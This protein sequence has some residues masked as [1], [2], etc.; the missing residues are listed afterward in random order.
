MGASY[1]SDGL[2]D[3][4]LHMLAQ[5]KELRVAARTSAF[6]GRNPSVEVASIGEQLNVR[7]VLEGS[8]QLSGSEIR[9]TAQLIDVNSGYHLWSGGFDRELKDIFVIQ[10]EIAAEVVAALKLSLLGY[11]RE[12]LGI[13]ATDNIE[14]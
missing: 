4:L 12:N 7:A 13:H 9:V 14:A 10:D 6:Q 11:T 1:F 2:A 8:V 5:I 3:T